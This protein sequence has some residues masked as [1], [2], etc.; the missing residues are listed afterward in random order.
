MSSNIKQIFSGITKF[1]NTIFAKH[2]PSE[3]PEEIIEVK[4][5]E[6]ISLLIIDDNKDFAYALKEQI[7]S[8]IEPVIIFSKSLPE[9]I[10]YISSIND[11]QKI[12]AVYI[13]AD[14]MLDIDPNRSNSSGL[15]ILKHIRLTEHLG[16]KRLLPVIVGMWKE[17]HEYIN[18]NIDN[19]I[20]F[21]PG[22]VIF[23]L[24][25]S[26]EEITNS[27]KKSKALSSEDL[28][29]VLSPFFQF[30]FN[31]RSLSQHDLRNKIGALKLLDEIEDKGFEHDPF[32]EEY[33]KFKDSSLW[34]KKAKFIKNTELNY[35]GENNHDV[36]ALD[37]FRAK[38]TNKR[39]LYID[40][41][42]RLGWS[43]A[44]YKLLKGDIDSKIFLKSDHIISTY[45]N[46]FICIDS[47]ESAVQ[48]LEQQHN[49]LTTLLETWS[50]NEVQLTDAEQRQR[51]A[52]V[53]IGNIQN[54]LDSAKKESENSKS[55]LDIAEKNYLSSCQKFKT[56]AP[57]F[58]LDVAT[59]FEN[60]EM[61]IED[62]PFQKAI[63]GLSDLLKQYNAANDSRLKALSQF[64]LTK[65]P[66][67]EVVTEYKLIKANFDAANIEVNNCK[68][69]FEEASIELDQ[70]FKLDLVILDLRLKKDT[71]ANLGTEIL[72]SVKRL[73]P[74][75]PVIIFTGVDTALTNEK[76]VDLGANGYWV[77]SES[78]AD[79]LKYLISTSTKNKSDLI[80]LW[81]Q[82]IKVHSKSNI[83]Y[84]YFSSGN[85]KILE[86][87]LEQNYIEKKYI[88]NWLI[89]SFWL[90]LHQP[91]E[92]ESNFSDFD[93]FSKIIL[94]IGLIQE[95]C[96]KDIRDSLWAKLVSDNKISK[97]EDVL[98]K[99]RNKIAHP[100]DNKSYSKL[101][102]KP[103]ID[104]VLIGIETTLNRLFRREA[105]IHENI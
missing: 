88:E 93:S 70:F 75:I 96:F 100:W 16:E 8:L 63:R 50:K 94:N 24:P 11:S 99:L 39:V 64:N 26:I 31:D 5:K 25:Q 3:L 38:M 59:H 17:P 81:L 1:T 45:K 66:Y 44:L 73:N 34:Y 92:F 101:S 61:E 22:C 57:N 102:E 9:I 76:T 2:E 86:G 19:V 47:F 21:S 91:T 97:Q 35:E 77:K 18:S 72:N 42:H 28:H 30:S 7:G 41:E 105:S 56:D 53:K 60:K 14:L 62:Q 43:Y 54:K 90:L 55:R 103:N 48:F 87:R 20:L 32:L 84:N 6:K 12:D 85:N 104:A 52:A 37:D 65:S 83:Y 67:D 69:Q 80:T 10:K 40:D 23:R 98:R 4:P 82:I 51:D 33:N 71:S 15:E 68:K 58:E 78:T 13:S 89:E 29:K 27:C 36:I 95:V 79:D 74:A 46:D 49:N